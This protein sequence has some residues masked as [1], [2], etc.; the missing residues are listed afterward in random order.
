MRRIFF[1]SSVSVGNIVDISGVDQFK[2]TD[3]KVG[4]QFTIFSEKYSIFSHFV[5]QNYLF[6]S[7]SNLGI[8]VSFDVPD[9]HVQ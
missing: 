5:I 1:F 3:N 2:V 7:R 4:T 8:F 6:S 9:C